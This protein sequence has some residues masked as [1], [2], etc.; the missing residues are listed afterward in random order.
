MGTIGLFAYYCCINRGRI[1]RSIM[2]QKS[3]LAC[4]HKTLCRSSIFSY[5]INLL[6]SLTRFQVE[7]I[8]HCAR[9]SRH[10]NKYLPYIETS[11]IMEIGT[12]GRE[13]SVQE[14]AVSACHPTASTTIILR[15]VIW[16]GFELYHGIH[17]RGDGPSV[18][19][20][21]LARSSEQLCGLHLQG[22]KGSA[23]QNIHMVF[24]LHEVL[25]VISRWAP[26]KT[27][28]SVAI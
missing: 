8:A 13:N 16:A 20:K 11:Q 2:Y 23:K 1:L 12:G 18:D 19:H 6:W 14:W 5:S 17:D 3:G 4:V 25:T 22:E 28:S 27:W 7:Q 10:W 9:R 26:Y 15:V 21:H 24:S